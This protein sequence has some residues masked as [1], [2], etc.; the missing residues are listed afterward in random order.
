[1]NL[2]GAVYRRALW[3]HPAALAYLRARG[4]PCWLLRRSGLGWADGGTLAAT[5]ARHPDPRL[6]PTA[7]D[8]G[9]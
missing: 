8:L 5:L 6:L 1:M 9:L 3:A 7:L 4:L 2:A